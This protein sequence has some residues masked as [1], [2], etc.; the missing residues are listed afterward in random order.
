MHKED[1]GTYYCFAENGVGRGDRRNVN[2]EIEF[3][4]VI[5]V[6]RQR[7]SQALKNDVDLE[8]H[9]ESFPPPQVRLYNCY[10]FYK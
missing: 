2:L 3:P 5:T 4:P 9:V 1:R 10:Q 7:V 6:T 8:C